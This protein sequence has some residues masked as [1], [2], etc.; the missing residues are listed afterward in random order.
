[1]PMR[2][3]KVADTFIFCRIGKRK[4]GKKLGPSLKTIPYLP[5]TPKGATKL[6][7]WL[8]ETRFFEDICPRRPPL[9]I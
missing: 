3:K 2:R 8:S 7:P 9:N 1:M 4:S 5:G 6:A